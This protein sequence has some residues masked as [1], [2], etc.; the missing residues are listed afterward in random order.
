MKKIKNAF[1]LILLFSSAI[2]AQDGVPSNMPPENISYITLLSQDFSVPVEFKNKT[3]YRDIRGAGW[4]SD[5]EI[6]SWDDLV[7][8]LYETWAFPNKLFLGIKYGYFDAP[9]A[10]EIGAYKVIAPWIRSFYVSLP[11]G[12]SFSGSIIGEKTFHWELS[13]EIS[14]GRITP[15]AQEDT[16]ILSFSKG[17]YAVMIIAGSDNIPIGGIDKSLTEYYAKKV[18]KKIDV[19]ISLDSFG[20]DL[21]NYVDQQGILHSLQVKLDH[22]I[23]RYRQG[24][25]KIALTHINSF[26]NELNAQRGK[27]VSEQ[28]YQKLKGYADTIVNSLGGLM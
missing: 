23:E 17:K 15:T 16:I 3:N 14:L 21:P 7:Q 2:F 4:P 26:I 9:L 19:A 18:E 25:Y 6:L 13:Q 12:G 10:A 5:K 20:A 24:D 22:F 28:G 1:L 11:I 8:G 27:H